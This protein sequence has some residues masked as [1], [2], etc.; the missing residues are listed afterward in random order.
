MLELV[1]RTRGISAC[2]PNLPG[3]YMKFLIVAALLVLAPLVATAQKSI[4]AV[5]DDGRMLLKQDVIFLEC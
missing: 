2:L 1:A 3:K 4:L 5:S